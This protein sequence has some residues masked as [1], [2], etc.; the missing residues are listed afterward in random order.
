[1]TS[2]VSSSEAFE[3]S[4]KAGSPVTQS[5]LWRVTR[6]Y[7]IPNM[8][9]ISQIYGCSLLARILPDARLRRERGA[10]AVKAQF[11]GKA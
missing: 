7:Q 9:V 3:L 10:A 8:L 5:P 11:Y 2:L 4:S 1:M 6:L